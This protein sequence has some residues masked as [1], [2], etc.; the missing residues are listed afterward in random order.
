MPDHTGRQESSGSSGYDGNF[1][2]H[3]STAPAAPAA[4]SAPRT[5]LAPGLTY[6]G[7]DGSVYRQ[8]PSVGW[9][10]NT[11]STWQSVPRTQA[12]AL[13]QHAISHTMGEQRFNNFRSVGGG[14]SRPAGGFVHAGGGGGHR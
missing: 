10:R 8:T 7:R 14:F 11:G 12:P 2:S 9:Q 6:S 4:H 13:E 5:T 3:I 1:H